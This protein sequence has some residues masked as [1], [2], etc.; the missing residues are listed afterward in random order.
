MSLNFNQIYLTLRKN[1]KKVNNDISKSLEEEGLSTQHATYLMALKENK[2]MSLAELT[3]FVDNDFALTSRIIKTLY[4]KEYVKK[5]TYDQRT[6]ISLTN[7]GKDL[8]KKIMSVLSLTK[9]KYFNKLSMKEFI[10]L[11]NIVKKLA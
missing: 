5:S 4:Q 7:K 10:N 1:F 6:K 9:K 2:E 8:C 11:K 3:S